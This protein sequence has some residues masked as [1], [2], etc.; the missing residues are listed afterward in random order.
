MPERDDDAPNEHAAVLPE[1]AV[2]DET[3]ENRS[4][5][6]RARVPLVYAGTVLDVEP[7]PSRCSRGRRV[8]NEKPPHP[9]VAEP[10][11]HL[12]EE[13]RGQPAG[14]PEPARVGRDGDGA[15]RG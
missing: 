12:R 7:Q 15:R 13:E 9:V 3:A 8:Q 14:M 5:P 10:L 4:E 11:P 6:D 1:E 2:R